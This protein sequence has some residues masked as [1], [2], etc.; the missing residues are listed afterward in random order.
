MTKTAI[1]ILALLAFGRI[2]ISA[3]LSADE[4]G[5]IMGVKATATPDGV[6]R[7]AWPRKEVSVQVDGLAMRPFMGLGTW[8]AFQQ[9]HDVAMLMGDTV[10]FED[11]VNPAI[12][13][14]FANG[15][16]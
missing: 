15:L 14:A 13:A 7:V 9:S 6:V 1:L 10:L 8:A 5:Q 2:G 12:D 16:E 11:E 3:E 4:I